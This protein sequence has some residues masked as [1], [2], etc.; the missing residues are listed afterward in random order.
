M[1]IRWDRV[2][3]ARDL[4]GSSRVTEVTTGVIVSPAERVS[5]YL[6][7]RMGAGILWD[8]LFDM[9]S[10]IGFRIH[11]RNYYAVVRPHLVHLTVKYGLALCG[12]QVRALALGST[13]HESAPEYD[14]RRVDVTAF[15]QPEWL[16]D[17]QILD[18]ILTL[19]G[20]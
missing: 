10:N 11:A 20:E 12:F 9:N 1:A 13:G 15:K 14:E 5:K 17:N 4:S 7:D 8:T 19:G 18:V 6:G 2:E 3:F 16:R